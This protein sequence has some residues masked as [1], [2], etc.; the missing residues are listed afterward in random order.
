MRKKQQLTKRG[1]FKK[2][3]ERIFKN[4]QVILSKNERAKFAD[5]ELKKQSHIMHH[6]GTIIIDV[7]IDDPFASVIAVFKN[8]VKY[9]GYSKRKPDDI[10]NDKIAIQVAVSSLIKR[11][12]GDS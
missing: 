1:Y 12:K 7:D 8:K 10:P 4:N 2:Y 6:E 3:R 5:D 9:I 11:L